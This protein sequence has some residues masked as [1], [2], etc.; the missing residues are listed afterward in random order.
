MRRFNRDATVTVNTTARTITVSQNGT[1]LSTSNLNT[2][3]VSVAC[4]VGTCPTNNTFTLRAPHGTLSEDIQVTVTRN[5]HSRS[6]YILG[7]VMVV[8]RR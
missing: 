3:T 2:V 6:S 7:P 4:R 5:T 1:T 8:V